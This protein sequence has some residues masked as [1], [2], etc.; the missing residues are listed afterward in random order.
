MIKKRKIIFT[1]K[2][3]VPKMA[4]GGR[5]KASRVC[6]PYWYVCVRML[7]RVFGLFLIGG[8]QKRSVIGINST[9]SLQSIPIPVPTTHSKTGQDRPKPR[10][11]A[12][13]V[14]AIVDSCRLDETIID[15]YSLV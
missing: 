5:D 13:L 9:F 7:L 10:H 6:L 2:P 3:T 11:S 15:C 4:G 14:Y 1:T 12:Y 8:P